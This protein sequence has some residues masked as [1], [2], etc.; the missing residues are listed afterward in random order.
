M[1]RFE[2]VIAFAVGALLAV[3]F[4]ARGQLPEWRLAAEPEA[5]F[6]GFS[7]VVDE[8]LSEL[9]GVRRL[10]DGRFVAGDPIAKHLQV[11]GP[12]GEWER[13][14][15]REGQGPGEYE[16]VLEMHRCAPGELWVFDAS[17]RVHRYSTSLEFLGTERRTYPALGGR[18]AYE[19]ACRPT[20]YEV[21]TGWG[22]FEQMK[23]GYFESRAP[24]LLLRNGEI[25]HDFG[26]WLSSQRIGTATSDGSL[27]GSGPHPLGRKTSVA[28]GTRHVYI[29]DAESAE[30][31]VFDLDGNPVGMLAWDGPSQEY[32]PA[33]VERFVEMQMANAPEGRRAAWRR[34][35]EDLPELDRLP[36]YNRILVDS[37]D[38]V[39]VREYSP[40]GS[41]RARW[42]IFGEGREPLGSLY[43]PREARVWDIVDDI[44]IYSVK[45]EFDVPVVKAQRLLTS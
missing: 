6:G 28:I 27:G 21:V 16:Y 35:Y 24:V 44:V 12:T 14:I 42:V 34:F 38:R 5:E 41:A 18:T 40:P 19:Q 22:D 29:G 25:V 2:P 15:G 43:M 8:S 4:V 45:D 1:T 26:V 36:A 11:F 20:G 39:W 13:T 9:T 32:S 33:I 17:A 30:I 10:P 3:P 7:A 23:V 31:S 37:Q